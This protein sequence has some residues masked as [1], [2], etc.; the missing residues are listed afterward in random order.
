ML[1]IFFAIQLVC[2]TLL[3][4]TCERSNMYDLAKY[5][6]PPQTAIYL[7]PVG[8]QA[9]AFGSR[10][11]ADNL[12]YQ[13]GI[14]YHTLVNAGTVKA[15]VSFSVVDELRFLVPIQY[16]YFPVMGISPTLT[17]TTISTSWLDLLSGLASPINTS[18]GL[19]N[20]N[21]FWTGSTGDG[22][23]VIAENCSGWNDST[24]AFNGRYGG[25]TIYDGLLACSDSTVYILCVAY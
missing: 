25:L 20:T 16:W 2:A 4:A 1:R 23:A 12:C 14:A 19:L 13:Q 8:P 5:G 24:G 21:Y 18:V 17:L 22:G 10:Y 11:N 6:L 7:F 15:F 3:L 9:G